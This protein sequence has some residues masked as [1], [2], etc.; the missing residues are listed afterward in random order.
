MAITKVTT[1][2]TDFDKISVTQGLKLPSGTNTNQPTGVQGVQGMI[3]N[4]T[5]ETTGSSASAI[6]HHNGTN[7]QYFAATESADPLVYSTFAAWDVGNSISYSGTGNILYNIVNNPNGFNFTKYGGVSYDST[8]KSFSFNGATGSNGAYMRFSQNAMNI[9]TGFTV[10]MWINPTSFTGDDVLYAYGYTPSLRQFVN[11][12]QMRYY[13]TPGPSGNYTPY[14]NHGMTTGNWYNITMVINN[15]N[16]ISP[17]TIKTY[18]S[19]EGDSTATLK[20]TANTNH[21][22]YQNTNQLYFGCNVQNYN[23]NFN[24]QLRVM[25]IYNSELNQTDIDFIVNQGSQ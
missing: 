1:P 16:A 7:W 25:E 23:S 10:S 15:S 20:Q 19:Q 3:R 5:D 8:N 9:P 4:D 24:G 11:S 14:F 17:T 22:A 13:I 12:S 18:I 21:G 2:V 6:E